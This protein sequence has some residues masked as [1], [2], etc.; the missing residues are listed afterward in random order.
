MSKLYFHISNPDTPEQS[1]CKN[2]CSKK[3]LDDIDNREDAIF[4]LNIH[5]NW[6]GRK[7]SDNY[8]FD[9]ANYIRTLKR[10]LSPI[11]FYSPIQKEYFE[12]KSRTNLKYKL[13]FGRGSSFIESPFTKGDLAEV[14]ENTPRL[15]QSSLHDVV[16][17]LA[18]VKGIVLDRLNHNLK[19]K[20]DI[21]KYFDEIE[22][23]LTEKQK[24]LVGFYEFREKLLDS[25]KE[26]NETEFLEIK[27]SFLSVCNAQ[28][29]EKGKDIPE[30]PPQKYK[31]LVIEDVK[32]ELDKALQNLEKNFEV[33]ALTN[34]EKAIKILKKDTTNEILAVISDWRLYEGS[35]QTY[36]Q[37]YQGYEVLDAASKSGIRA[38]FALTSQADFI[39]H[40]IRNTLGFKFSLMKKQNLKNSDQWSLFSDLIYSGCVEVI[41]KISDM[42]GSKNWS[43]DV[44]GVSYKSIY[45]QK[46]SS[47][48][49]DV[50]FSLVNS[51]ANEVWEYLMNEFDKGFSDLKQIKYLFGLEVP[52]KPL[53]LSKVLTLRL[54]WLGLSYKLETE[55]IPNDNTFDKP[56]AKVYKIICTGFYG[57]PSDNEIN[58]ELNKVCLTNRDIQ[59]KKLLPHEQ[60]WLKEK[61]LI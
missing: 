48:E 26:S 18:D 34:A 4:I 52:K 6:D 1:D 55:K 33:I 16:T 24:S 19:F 31:I 36:W 60:I 14:V 40:H 22:P 43:N 59:Q 56:I 58:V 9:I 11:I 45:Q 46:L 17:M 53:N 50:F 7:L 32:E 21:S 10:S 13:L 57:Y 42:P 54:I 23:Y 37:K 30:I 41:S 5:L 39:V 15:N 2:I 25:N 47:V 44:E 35:S 12:Y 8:G 38:L 27:D 29:T 61:G 3:E 20:A 51:K 49:N 28:L